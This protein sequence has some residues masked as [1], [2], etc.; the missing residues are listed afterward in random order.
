[1]NDEDQ[2]DL[3]IHVSES[4]DSSAESEAYLETGRVIPFIQQNDNIVCEDAKCCNKNRIEFF[5]SGTFLVI[6]STFLLIILPLYSDAVNVVS[7]VY[8]LILFTSVVSAMILLVLTCLSGKSKFC[9]ST[10]SKSFS[11][12]IRLS[13]LLQAGVAHGFGGLLVLFAVD[14]KKVLCHLQDPIK[15]VSLV[16][17]LMFY[18]LCSRKCKYETYSVTYFC[19]KCKQ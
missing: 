9:K 1:M 11:P 4:E 5:C 2:E 19:T 14:S 6:A 16:F 15:G 7:D 8:T 3:L 18:F 13:L 17:A 10:L 12:P